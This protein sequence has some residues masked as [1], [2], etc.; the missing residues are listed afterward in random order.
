MRLATF[1]YSQANA[2]SFSPAIWLPRQLIFL[3]PLGVGSSLVASHLVARTALLCFGFAVTAYV[4]RGA[5]FARIGKTGVSWW[6]LKRWHKEEWLWVG[7]K[8]IDACAYKSDGEAY[9]L[10]IFFRRI[11]NNWPPLAPGSRRVQRAPGSTVN[12]RALNFCWPAMV[13]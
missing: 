8:D 3:A 12:S 4:R 13:P 6:N 11:P 1:F 5:A 7:W 2:P 9:I 10:R